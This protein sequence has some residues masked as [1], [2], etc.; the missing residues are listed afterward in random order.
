MK[1]VC[2]IWLPE[3]ERHFVDML[4]ESGNYQKDTFDIAMEYVKEPKLFWDIGAHVG[5]WSI[6]AYKAGF[7]EITAFEP[8]PITY[9]CLVKNLDQLKPYQ[10]SKIATH[11]FGVGSSNCSMS[12]FNEKEGNSGAVKLIPGSAMNIYALDDICIKYKNHGNILPHET[13]LKIDVEGMEA[14]CIKGMSRIINELHPVICVEQRT[15]NDALEILQKMGMEIVQI[16]RKD[17]ILTWKNQ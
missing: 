4:G 15:N 14:E 1:Q 7:H 16:V 3:D 11:N 12:I 17:Y 10:T 2:G 13:L 9:K 6:M 8:N 5:T